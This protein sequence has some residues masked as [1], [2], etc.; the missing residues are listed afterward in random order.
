V[1]VCDYLLY[2]WFSICVWSVNKLLKNFAAECLLSIE[3]FFSLDKICIGC[4]VDTVGLAS[5]R[6]SGV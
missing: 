1:H 2:L 4:F 6:A 5:E 3:S